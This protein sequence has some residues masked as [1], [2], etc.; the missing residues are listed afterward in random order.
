M[1]WRW[2]SDHTLLCWRRRF[3]ASRKPGKQRLRKPISQRRSSRFVHRTGVQVRSFT[4]WLIDIQR[5]LD[6]NIARLEMKLLKYSGRCSQ[7]YRVPR[8]QEVHRERLYGKGDSVL[9]SGWWP[10]GGD[11][12]RRGE[13]FSRSQC[14][15]GSWRC[16]MWMSLSVHSASSKVRSHRSTST[17]CRSHRCR[18]SIHST[19][20]PRE[21]E[22]WSNY[23][24]QPVC[25]ARVTAVWVTAHQHHWN[26]I[27]LVKLCIR[28]VVRKMGRIYQIITVSL[29][30]QLYSIRPLSW[31]AN[32]SDMPMVEKSNPICNKLPLLVHALRHVPNP[33]ILLWLGISNKG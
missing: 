24:S 31:S 18:L 27:F 25:A 13:S 30:T 28:A 1:Y 22:P 29:I 15:G 9:A 19:K 12:N 21:P 23:P 33:I 7:N 4:P 17:V 6:S 14:Q 26:L 8:W 16:W 11:G 20:S 5:S 2:L 10:R 3:S 32:Q